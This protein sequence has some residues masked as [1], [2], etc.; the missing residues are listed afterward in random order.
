[1]AERPSPV[2][3][4]AGGG[5]A[6]AADTLARVSAR[7]VPDSFSIACLLT[8]FT[9]ALGMTLGLSASVAMKAYL[10]DDLPYPHAERL[11]SVR[12]SAPGGDPPG[13]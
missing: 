5:L 9:L 1:M 12:Y 13:S 11:Y 2:P 4:E 8:L 7:W 6:R 3:D 10:L